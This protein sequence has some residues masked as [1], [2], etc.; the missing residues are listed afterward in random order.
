MF[1][2]LKRTYIYIILAL[3]YIPLFV[4]AIYSFSKGK[5]KGDM[6]ISFHRSGEGWTNLM[7]DSRIS[8]AIINTTFIALFVGLIVVSL[9]L[10]TVFGLWRQKNIASKV[11]VQSTSSIPLINPDI[12]TAVSMSIAFGTMFGA[13]QKGDSGY[14]RLI[15]SQV[16]MIIPFAI[17][18]MYPRSE[19]FKASLFE[20]S[21]D[22]GYG[23]IKTW[24]KTYFRH[25]IFVSIVSFM[26]S[27]SLSL[28][29]FVI[30]RIVSKEVTIGKLMYEGTLQPWVLAMGTIALFLTL[31]FSLFVSFKTFIKE[32]KNNKVKNVK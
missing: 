22:L 1:K 15:I 21:K 18:I 8:Y 26:I 27:I 28:D 9:S 24:F 30:T 3:F 20:A 16:T 29:D 14:E 7:N 10:I 13:L 31:S 6:L 12:I 2:F 11:Y 5:A 25:M 17:V 4:G 32:K 19:K 23:P